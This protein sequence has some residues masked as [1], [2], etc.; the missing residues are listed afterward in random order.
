VSAAVRRLPGVHTDLD[1]T[2]SHR[3][4]EV[5]QRYTTN[6]RAL[7][8][9][10]AAEGQPLTIAEILDRR[11]DLAQSS[12]YRNLTALEQ[13]GVVSRVVTRSEWGHY[14]LAEDLTRHHH[15]VVCSGCGLVRDIELPP[16]LERALDEILDSTDGLDGFVV[17]EHRLDLVG[18]CVSCR[19]TG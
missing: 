3:L 18:R 12:V 2:V 11:R 13:A 16:G 8:E 1:G 5:G 4:Q 19:E 15:H 9:L 17:E 7:V 14:E 10:L 6:R